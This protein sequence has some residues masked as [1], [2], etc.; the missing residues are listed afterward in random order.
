[1]QFFVHVSRETPDVRPCHT[2]VP[3]GVFG[4]DTLIDFLSLD[5]HLTILLDTL[6]DFLSLD[7]H[8]TILLIHLPFRRQGKTYSTFMNKHYDLLNPIDFFYTP[9]LQGQ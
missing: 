8:L 9:I 6:I 3:Q 2:S 5:A 1:M 4:Q 7:A